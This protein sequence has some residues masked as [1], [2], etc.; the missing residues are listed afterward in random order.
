M[1]TF[2]LPATPCEVTS[3][4]HLRENATPRYPQVAEYYYAVALPVPLQKPP[5][6]QVAVLCA[7]FSILSF[8]PFLYSAVRR[9]NVL[10]LCLSVLHHHKAFPYFKDVSLQVVVAVVVAIDNSLAST[11]VVN[12]GVCFFHIL[13][14]FLSG[15]R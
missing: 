14:G 15:V 9:L 2:R 7:S 6:F 13:Y 10:K 12:V 3:L 4:Y 8:D 5:L 11:G 1:R